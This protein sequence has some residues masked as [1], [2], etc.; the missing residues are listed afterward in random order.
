MEELKTTPP[1]AEQLATLQ[2]SEQE[3]EGK[4]DV[5]ESRFHPHNQADDISTGSESSDDEHQDNIPRQELQM[6][7]SVLQT[8]VMNSATATSETATSATN[9]QHDNVGA[10]ELHSGDP[11]SPEESGSEYEY[12]SQTTPDASVTNEDDLKARSDELMPPTP[13]SPPPRHNFDSAAIERRSSDD[14]LDTESFSAN[15]IALHGINLK[16]IKANNLSPREQEKAGVHKCNILN[17]A[18]I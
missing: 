10:E 7:I 14:I 8:T 3:D 17:F 16:D 18:N 4:Q 15:L 5:A 12:G 6:V 2:V 1:S 9:G 13:G 11:S